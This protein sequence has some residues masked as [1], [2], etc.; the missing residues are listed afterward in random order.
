MMRLFVVGLLCGLSSLTAQNCV[1]IGPAPG[2]GIGGEW[3]PI[4]SST[5]QAVHWRRQVLIPAIWF[6]N[7]PTL[8]RDVA[9]GN[10]Y[11]WVTMEY[12]Q[13]QVRMGHTSVQN[14]NFQFANNIT[15]QMQLV[16]DV[17]DHRTTYGPGPVW[18]ELGLQQPFQFVPGQGNLLIDFTIVG[19]TKIAN[20][21]LFSWT[22]TYSNGDYDVAESQ[23]STTP[24][25]TSSGGSRATLRLCTDRSWANVFGSGCGGALEPMLGVSGDPKLGG[26]V[27]FWLSNAGSGLPAVLA[28]GFDNS[29]P[30]PIDL[31]V[32]GAP[33]CRQYFAISNVD[34][35]LTNGFGFG[36]HTIQVPVN[37]A[38]VGAVV[39]GQFAAL[40]P[41]ANALGLRTSA[42]GRIQVGL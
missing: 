15:S 7:V 3:L 9:V 28:F 4:V 36:S 34:G 13:L 38:L 5:G 14:L 39:L 19:S 33:G 6:A 21:A 32:V 27:S 40:A 24:P 37:Q 42:Y 22:K 2:G 23:F 31:G 11:G 1:E 30:F 10:E 16:L 35:L 20:S 25:Q 29:P 8:I 12:G 18:S 26:S 41:G 17:N